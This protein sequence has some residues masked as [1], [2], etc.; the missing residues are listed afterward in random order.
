MHPDPDR[1]NS[2]FVNSVVLRRNKQMGWEKDGNKPIIPLSSAV[3][4]KKTFVHAVSSDGNA[5]LLV[6]TKKVV[7]GIE[8]KTVLSLRCYMSEP[9]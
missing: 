5:N 9:L 4:N 7:K 8:T 1:I 6:N 2:G 3:V